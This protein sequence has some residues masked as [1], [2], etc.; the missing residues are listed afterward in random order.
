MLDWAVRRMC[1]A[2]IK[3]PQCGVVSV[4]LVLLLWLYKLAL[5]SSE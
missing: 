3:S 2:K 1:M 4:T 5:L